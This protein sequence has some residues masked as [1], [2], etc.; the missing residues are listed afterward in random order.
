V[1]VLLAFIFVVVVGSVWETTRD[2]SARALPLAVL[3]ALVAV[4]L[5]TMSRFV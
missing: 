1:K 3:S 2:R 5:F 4:V